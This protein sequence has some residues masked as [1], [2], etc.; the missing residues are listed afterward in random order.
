MKKKLYE[1]NVHREC[2]AEDLVHW[3]AKGNIS[4]AGQSWNWQGIQI[5]RTK[6]AFTAEHLKMPSGARSP[7]WGEEVS[8]SGLLL[9]MDW[10]EAFGFFKTC[11]A[12][13]S[14]DA[15]IRPSVN[16]R[17]FVKGKYPVTMIVVAAQVIA[18]C[19]PRFMSWTACATFSW[20]GYLGAKA[21]SPH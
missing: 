6:E 2:N 1:I 12:I 11:Q 9:G 8:W 13:T 7:N 18:V 3:L 17:G 21:R 14:K 4:A 5:A 20:Q 16:F 10:L 19:P 15:K